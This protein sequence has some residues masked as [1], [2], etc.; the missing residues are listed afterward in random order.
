MGLNFNSIK[1]LLL[2]HA[3][4]VS[5]DRVLMIGRQSVAIRPAE[6]RALARLPVADHVRERLPRLDLG[7]GAYA[8]ELLRT[9]GASVVESMDKTA[10]EGA[11]TLHDLNLPVP[12]GLSSGFDLIVDG[13]SLEHVFNIPMAIRNYM[14]MLKVGGYYFCNTAT[15]NYSGHGFYQLSPEFFFAAFSPENGFSIVEAYLYEEDG[16]NAWYRLLPPAQAARRMTFQNSVPAHL[17]V[18]ARKTREGAAFEQFPQQ[19]MYSAAWERAAVD[20]PS[21]S[22]RRV[23]FGL[24]TQLPARMTWFVLNTWNRRNRFRK[25][26]FLRVGDQ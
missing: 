21:T 5:F 13:G 6:V 26:L 14:T 10:Y 11:T 15:N 18:L 1:L 3:R 8:E 7:R 25:D 9:L 2:A 20:A 22:L 17:L 19:R 4:G 16:R 24:V 12:P 23:V